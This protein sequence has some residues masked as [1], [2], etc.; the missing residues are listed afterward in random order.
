[1][2][3]FFKTALDSGKVNADAQFPNFHKPEP[4]VR[5]EEP[6]EDSDEGNDM[7][8]EGGPPAD[9]PRPPEKDE[10]EAPEPQPRDVGNRFPNDA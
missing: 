3:D 7:Q 8:Q 6:E 2:G 10:P 4:V 1:V 9:L 5:R